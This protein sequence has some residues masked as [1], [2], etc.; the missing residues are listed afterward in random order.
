M[1]RATFAAYRRQQQTLLRQLRNQAHTEAMAEAAVP[2]YSNRNPLIGHIFWRR[3]RETIRQIETTDTPRRALDA[4]CGTGVLLPYLAGLAQ[5][6]VAADLDLGPLQQAAQL[7]PLPGNVTTLAADICSLTDHH[8]ATFNLITA[9]DC[10]EHVDDLD[11][12]IRN[13][14]ALMEPGGHLV[15]S[16]PTENWAYRL[17]RRIAGRE[18]SGDYHHRN[19]G[20][21]RK[22]VEQHFEIRTTRRF[23]APAPLFEVFLARKN[24]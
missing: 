20:D 15:V 4:G 2:A 18:Y 1:D 9:L 17:G 24:A 11:L 3:L 16:G 12:A 6:V 22:V 8:L 7:R 19:I 13:L 5:E 14:S 23:P 21:I 10:L